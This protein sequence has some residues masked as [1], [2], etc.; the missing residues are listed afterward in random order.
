MV[1]PKCG[2]DR[3]AC[4]RPRIWGISRTN[5]IE[6][7]VRRICNSCGHVWEDWQESEPLGNHKPQNPLI[8]A[9]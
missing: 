9:S 8:C 2:S 3:V 4:A 6:G 5:R 1:C 7:G